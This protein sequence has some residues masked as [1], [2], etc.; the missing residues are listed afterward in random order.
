MKPLVTQLW[1]QFTADE[2]FT[3]CFQGVIV[4]HVK[5]NREQKKITIA[6]TSAAPIS[7]EMAQRLSASLQQTLFTGYTVRLR[8][9]FSYEYLTPQ[10][11]LEIAEELKEEG[12]P[13]NGFLNGAVV[14]I[15]GQNIS[16]CVKNGATL[17]TQI[18]FCDRMA[19]AVAQRTGIRPQAVSYTHLTLPT[20]LEV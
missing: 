11:F 8:G 5:A 9:S 7:L 12:L 13:V 20:K 15:E 17:L 18:G 3:R 14:Q 4:D 16:V 6:C 19:D 10:A 2:E 1:P